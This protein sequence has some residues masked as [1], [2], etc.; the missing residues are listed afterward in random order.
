LTDHRQAILFDLDGTLIDTTDLI[1]QCFHFSWNTVCSFSHSRETL[2]KTFGMPLRDA[3]YQLLTA[4]DPKN[5]IIGTGS[6]EQIIEKLL[7]AYRSFNLSNHDS[8]ARPF[9]GACDVLKELRRR[10]YL[11]AVVTSKSRELGLRGLRLCSLDCLLDSAIFLEDTSFHKPRPEPI[12]AALERLSTRSASAVYVGDSRHD[13]I[14][15]R[16]AGVRAVAA[17]WGPSPRTELESERPNFVAESITDLL[18]LFN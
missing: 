8:L 17:L 10:G 2:I 16:A 6:D 1:V 3:M 12:L 11:I 5:D 7:A 4:G 14:A 18:D 9:R 13:I 15:A